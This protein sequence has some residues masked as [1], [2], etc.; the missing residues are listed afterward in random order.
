[1]NDD[2]SARRNEGR[3]PRVTARGNCLITWSGG[4]LIPF[5]IMYGG[6]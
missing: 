3:N 6:C 2:R 4:L 5:I 1:M